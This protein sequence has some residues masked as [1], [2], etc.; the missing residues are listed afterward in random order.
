[1]IRY[2]RR[3]RRHRRQQRFYREHSV[4]AYTYGVPAVFSWGEG[5]TLRIGKFCSIAMNVKIFLGGEHRTDWISTYPFPEQFR[6]VT[7]V[8]GHPFSRG[9]VLIGN[10]VWIGEGVTIMSGVTIGDG[11]V[12]GAEA[13][14]TRDVPPYA[15][16]AGNPARLLRFRFDAAQ[17]DRLLSVRWWDWPVEK[18]IDHAPL[19]MGD[20]LDDFLAR[21]TPNSEKSD[22]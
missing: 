17:I 21:Y 7:P 2:I 10:D 8:P 12:L 13:V 5:S 1:M 16:V 9:D 14:I 4:G 11:A 15:I 18:V 19:L 22:A 3:W 6:R 20:Q